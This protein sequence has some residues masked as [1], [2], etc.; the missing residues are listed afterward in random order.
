MAGR[1]VVIIA[2]S[3]RILLLLEQSF[4]ILFNISGGDIIQRLQ[5][6]KLFVFAEEVAVGQ[7]RH[8]AFGFQFVAGML[9]ARCRSSTS[10]C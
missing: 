7:H 4:D 9:R 10:P 6:G 3:F 5:L 1:C 2:F 8:Q